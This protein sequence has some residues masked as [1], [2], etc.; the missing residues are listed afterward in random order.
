MKNEAGERICRVIIEMKFKFGTIIGTSEER[1]S[2][3]GQ[4]LFALPFFLG[5]LLE[6]RGHLLVFSTGSLARRFFSMKVC[7][8][9]KK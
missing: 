9:I 6:Y 8:R 2:G 3:S 1:G 4:L 5:Y 7:Q